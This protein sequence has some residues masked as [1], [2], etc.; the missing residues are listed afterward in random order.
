MNHYK[1]WS[2]LN[3]QLSELLCD[4]LKN[5]LSYFLTRYHKVHNSYGMAAIQLDRRELVCFSW[6]EAYHQEYD[7]HKIGMETG[8][9]DYDNPDL[10][11]KWDA[12]ATYHDTDF[13]LAATSFL[14]TPVM[15]SLYSDNYIIRIFAIVDR[16]I[17]KR[18][19][20][21]IKESGDYQNFPTWVKQFYELRLESN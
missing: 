10:K 21:K 12:N 9:W 11:S 8:V 7:V 15:E 14:Q 1:S 17:G 6:I 18:T 19:L 16:R 13:L 5:H 20:H 2:K 4:E 3:K